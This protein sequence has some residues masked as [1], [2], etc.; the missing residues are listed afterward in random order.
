MDLTTLFPSSSPAAVADVILTH[1]E[2]AIPTS[3]WALPRWEQYARWNVP[4]QRSE[5][6]RETL[7]LWRD[8]AGRFEIQRPVGSLL[9]W[10]VGDGTHAERFAVEVSS[11]YFGADTSADRL[12][13]CR[14]R[15]AAWGCEKKFNPIQVMEQNPEAALLHLQE[16]VDC[17][18]STAF[19]S[20]EGKAYGATILRV[21]HTALRAGGVALIQIGYHTGSEYVTPEHHASFRPAGDAGVTYQLGEFWTL[22]LDQGFIPLQVILNP[23]SK[24][25]FYLLRK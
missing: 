9:E 1:G 22:A 20:F 4:G 13:E 16:P 17:F 12:E 6:A 21:A 3:T 25:A 2:H 23:P 19:S 11:H 14:W 10:G 24:K 7:T 15:M 5:V 8:L 18:L